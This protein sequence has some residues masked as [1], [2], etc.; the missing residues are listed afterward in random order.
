MRATTS[1]IPIFTT[2]TTPIPPIVSTTITSQQQPLSTPASLKC[3]S[4]VSTVNGKTV[5]CKNSI[6]FNEDFNSDN[7]K[8]WSFDSRF[9]LDD[10]TA[11]AEFTVYEKR[12]ETSFIRDNMMVIKAESLKRTLGFD[13]TR[14]RM[15]NYN[16]KER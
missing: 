4:A 2:T 6:I 12:A 13:D 9:P 11:D 14:I 10:T 8:Y 15:G 7:L 16:L 1:T 5:G 3:E